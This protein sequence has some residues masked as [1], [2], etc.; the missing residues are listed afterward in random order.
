[1]DYQCYNV[2][3]NINVVVIYR[4]KKIIDEQL[5]NLGVLCK[6]VFCKT[7]DNQHFN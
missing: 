6:C 3:S 5:L 2:I 1:M 7:L 4:S